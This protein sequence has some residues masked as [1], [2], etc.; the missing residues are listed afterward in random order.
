MFFS[1][2]SVNLFSVLGFN[3]YE[4]GG[5]VFLVSIHICAGNVSVLE[6]PNSVQQM[7]Q[8]IHVRVFLG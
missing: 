6:N 2:A 8:F 3:S 7:F 1:L 4:Y 5:D